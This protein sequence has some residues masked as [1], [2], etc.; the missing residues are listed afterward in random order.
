MGSRFGN[1]VLA[2]GVAGGLAVALAVAGGVQAGAAPASGQVDSMSDLKGAWVA[3]LTGFMDGEPA[4]W[5]HRLTV[6]KVNGSAAVAWEEWRDCADHAAACEANKATGGGWSSPSR[7]LLV[8]DT[9]GTVHGVGATGTLELTPAEGGMNA[10]M[11]GAGKQ[12]DP[13]AS[14]TATTTSEAGTAPRSAPSNKRMNSQ[15]IVGGAYAVQGQ[16]VSDG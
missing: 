1:R 14:P 5:Q 2:A 4:N 11:L 3:T 12:Q 15:K 13:A 7:V 10:V 9:K 16:S 6:R 8:M